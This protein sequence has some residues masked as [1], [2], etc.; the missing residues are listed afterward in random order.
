[1]F[2]KGMYSDGPTASFPLA[3]KDYATVCRFCPVTF[4][5][6]S[7]C[8][9][10]ALLSG[11]DRKYVWAVATHTSILLYASTSARPLAVF[12]DFHYSS[13]FDLTWQDDRCVAACSNDGYISFITFE[14]GYFGTKF[15]PEP[16]N[17]NQAEL[18]PA[19]EQADPEPVVEPLIMAAPIR[20]KPQDPVEEPQIMAAPIRAKPV[21]TEAAPTN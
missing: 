15:D 2:A 8:D 14:P 20:A 13:V 18:S 1:M 10:N 16:E 4:Q 19:P 3:D 5:L 17:K 21:E 7:D 9:E 11:L 12:T 6:E